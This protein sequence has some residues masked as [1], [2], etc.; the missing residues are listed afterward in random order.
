[1]FTDLAHLERFTASGPVMGSRWSAVFHAPPAFDTRALEIA[2]AEAVTRVDRQMSTW[3]P[4]SDLERLSAAPVGVWVDI[5]RELTTVLAA[6][7]AIGAASDGAFDIGVGD[8]V[9]A[10]GFGG[11]A[12]RPDGR[13]IGDLAGRPRIAAPSALELDEVGLRARKHAPMRLDLGG[14]AKGFGVDEMAR[15]LDGFGIASWLAGIDGDMRA[16]GCKPDDAPWAVAHERPVVGRREAMG[17][18]ELV[19]LAVATSG[20]HRHFTEFDGR[21]VAHTMDPARGAPLANAVASVSVM[22]ETCMVADAW[23]TVLMVQG[24]TA[25]PE[26]ARRLGMSSVFVLADGRVIETA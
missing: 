19:D 6:A 4:A 9:T 5:P 3:N 7:L 26:T 15:V 16:R 18:F 20:T 2:L 24:E 10:W 17:V 23:A 14:I 12:R 21:T 1:M 11:G 13:A 8:L 25:G 22:A